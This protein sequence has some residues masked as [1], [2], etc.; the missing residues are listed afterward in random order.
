[1]DEAF[2]PAKSEF[3][4]TH[5]GN[6]GH[7]SNGKVNIMRWSD[8]NVVTCLS[9]FDTVSPVGMVERRANW[10]QSK[11]MVR[12]PLMMGNKTTRMVGIDLL[13]H[14][15]SVYKPKLKGRRSDGICL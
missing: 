8:N 13:Y 3:T 1:L 7:T 11:A 2:L 6:F 15:P 12:H 10:S 14:L 4:K 5:R 9:N